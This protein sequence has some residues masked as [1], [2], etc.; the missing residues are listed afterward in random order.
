MNIPIRTLE[1]KKLDSRRVLL[2]LK[3]G[4]FLK[5]PKKAYV[6]KKAFNFSL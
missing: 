5:R 1:H 4:N 2:L 6:A 3:V